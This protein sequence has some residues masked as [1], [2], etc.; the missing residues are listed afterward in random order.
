MSKSVHET[1]IGMRHPRHRAGLR[2]GPHYRPPRAGGG[3]RAPAGLC[4]V[5][6]LCRAW[7]AGA[8]W[9]VVCRAACGQWRAPQRSR[10]LERSPY[11]VWTAMDPASKLLLGMS[12]AMPSDGRC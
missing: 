1:Q 9:R 6:S 5:L 4:P 7:Q 10:G 2:G 3:G 12:T 8:T 11:R